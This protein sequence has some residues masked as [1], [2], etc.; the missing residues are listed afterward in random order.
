MAHPLEFSNTANNPIEV[1]EMGNQ[2]ESS[3]LGST[4]KEEALGEENTERNRNSKDSK[5]TITTLYSEMVEESL[6]EKIAA[7]REGQHE[8]TP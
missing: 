5:D 8:Y 7:I 2:S 4:F 1:K 3:E 6:N